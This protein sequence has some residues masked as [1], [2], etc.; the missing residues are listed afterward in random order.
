[1]ILTS[2]EELED[3]L[4]R[5][6]EADA[7]LMESL[8]GPLLILGAG[9]KMGPSLARRAVRAAEQAGV[10]RRV[11]AVSR[12]SNP[13]AQQRLRDWGVETLSAD[14]LDR[15]QLG[16]LPE[17]PHIIYLAARK[18]GST[19]AEHLTW[20]MNA[21]LPGLVAERYRYS[22]IVALS[23]GN[24]YPLLPVTSGGA[25]EETRLEPV[26]E[27]GQSVLARERIFEFFSSRYGTPV[28][29]VRLNY[30]VELRYGVLLD[31][32]LAVFERRPV[33]L[34]MGNVNVIWQGDANSVILRS[35]ALCSSPPQTLNLTGPETLSVRYIA[36]RFGKLF[37]IEPQFEGAEAPT[38]LLN[39]AAKCHRLF[40][41]PSVTPE[42]L[43]EW[44]ASWIGMGGVTHGKPTKFN[45]RDG[46]F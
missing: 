33:D 16:A 40:G 2:E 20:G 9:G 10:N 46:K 13:V 30:A 12:F 29:L 19:G 25:V 42:Q 1:M 6:S 28:C 7:R 39:N 23:S 4:S 34:S 17:A 26:G 11:I 41:Y 43:I 15:E 3:F 31:I 37:G 18:F 21:W 36:E 5:P 32:G 24:I 27:Y 38:A 35:F 22:R 44:T 45:V 14:L 8:E